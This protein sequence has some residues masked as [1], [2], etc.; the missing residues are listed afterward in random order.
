MLSSTPVIPISA[1]VQA[2]VADIDGA[3][4]RRSPKGQGLLQK[5]GPPKLS[6]VAI[7]MFFSKA[8]MELSTKFSLLLK[9]FQQKSACFQRAFVELSESFRRACFRRAF[10]ELS[11]SLRRAFR[12][13]SESFQRAF[14]E[15]AF[16]EFSES[17]RRAFGELS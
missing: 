8:F 7:Y 16:V 13:L 9:G 17:F 14:V 4:E 1:S 15:P 6:I 3:R 5:E 10:R 2:R 12:E 11:E